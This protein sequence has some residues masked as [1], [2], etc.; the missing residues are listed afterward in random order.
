MEIIELQDIEDV[1]DVEN[2]EFVLQ[3]RYIRDGENP[4]EFY[5]NLQFKKRYRFNKD[6]IHMLDLI[7]IPFIWYITKNWRRIGKN[8]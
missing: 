1:E 6:S 5:D 4:F 3:K 2:V 8:Q 7:I